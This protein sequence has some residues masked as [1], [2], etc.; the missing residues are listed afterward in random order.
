MKREV[1]VRVRVIS[2]ALLFVLAGVAAAQDFNPPYPRVVFQRPAENGYP[3]NSWGASARIFARFDLVAIPGF[4]GGAM[5]ADEIRHYN[6]KT[7]ILGTS[8]QGAWPGS[9]PPEFFAFRSIYSRL[10]EPVHAGASE[11]IV[12]TTEGFA[13]NRNKYL[14]VG[15]DLIRFSGID[16]NRVTGIPSSG[17]FAV[18]DHQANEPIRVPIRFGGFGYL[19]NLTD[20]APKVD[21]KPP[22]EYFI[23]YRMTKTDFSHFDGAF[24]DAFRQ[25]FYSEELNDVDFDNNG[26]N[27]IEEHGLKWVNN[28]WEAGIRAMLQYERQQ[29]SKVARDRRGIVV[30]NCGGGGDD[31]LLDVANGIMWEGFMRFAWNWQHMEDNLHLWMEKGQKPLLYIIEDYVRE[32][33]QDRG[34]NDFR[35]M[36]FGLTTALMGD[37]YYGR[38][39]GDYYYISLWYD[40]FETNLGYPTTDMQPVGNGTYARFFD[41]GV[42]ICNP[43]GKNVTVTDSDLR[44]LSGYAGPYYRFQGG[45]DPDFN[46][47]KPFDS[48]ELYGATG[49]REKDIRGDGILLFKQPTVAIADIYVGNHHNNDTSPGSAPVEYVGDWKPM[50]SKYNADGENNPYWTQ[51]VSTDCP[52]G[53][54]EGY[55][56]FVAPPG[57]GEMTATYRP[58][59]GVPGYYEVFEWHG[60]HG[61]RPGEYREASNVP[62][63][64]KHANGV[65]RGTIDQTR[66][67]GRWNSLGVYYFERGT[68]GYLKISNDANGYVI[69]DAIK[70]VYRGMNFKAD[71]Q[72]PA[73]PKGV[74]I[75]P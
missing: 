28:R 24:Y 17:E 54:C 45:Q 71:A 22:W 37:A 32:K 27:D 55:G 43:S 3:N 59:I 36:R 51:W 9:N 68:D 47:G 26:V 6:P 16:G 50:L 48:V 11:I 69:S 31:Y 72:P 63:E 62:F 40:E 73:P 41:N 10:A 33:K 66:N 1:S 42:A 8:K 29:I 60:W 39:F 15:D 65:R 75:V 18:Q 70:W 13:D 12:T 64:L 56:Y 44:G 46:N 23:D 61:D 4:E 14:F 74:H 34:K 57:H 58:T 25:I 21:G 49:S 38:T 20:V 30:V 67:I 53:A 2:A 52:Y 35:Y 19:P 7:V 5:F